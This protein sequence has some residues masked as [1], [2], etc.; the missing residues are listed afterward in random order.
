MP[1]E[2]DLR[3]QIAGLMAIRQEQTVFFAADDQLTYG[4]VSSVLSDLRKR[5]S[6]A[7]RG[8]AHKETSRR[9]TE[10]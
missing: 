7:Q 3:R 10:T 5:R 9:G 4:E 2:D 1:V 6:S 8:F